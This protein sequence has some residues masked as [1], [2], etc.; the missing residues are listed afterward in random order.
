MVT[1]APSRARLVAMAR[2]MPAVEPVTRAV[3]SLSFRSI[4]NLIFFWARERS[5]QGARGAGFQ[6]AS[7]RSRLSANGHDS[8]A[9]RLCVEAWLAKEAVNEIGDD[10]RVRIDPDK[11]I[12]WM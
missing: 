1:L 2:P 11:S 6:R 12:A 7:E 9:L 4:V 10:V 8:H 3:L 5:T